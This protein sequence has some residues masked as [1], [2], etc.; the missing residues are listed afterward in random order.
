MTRTLRAVL[1]SMGS[2]FIF[3]GPGPKLLTKS[4]ITRARAYWCQNSSLRTL[5]LYT[6]DPQ[7][8]SSDKI[9][10]SLA[11]A[12]DACGNVGLACNLARNH[13][14]HNHG[15]WPPMLKMTSRN[16]SLFSGVSFVMFAI[17]AACPILKRYAPSS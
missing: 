12:R 13:A 9:L 1:S 3:P 11:R 7:A 14:P 15:V 10:A 6:G 16:C 4:V 17:A 2:S 5:L 8:V